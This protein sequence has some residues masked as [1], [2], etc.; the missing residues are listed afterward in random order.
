[1]MWTVWCSW[2]CILSLL[3]MFRTKQEREKMKQK[4]VKNLVLVLCRSAAGGQNCCVSMLHWCAC[5][6][7][8]ISSQP[9]PSTS[10]FMRSPG[11]WSDVWVMAEHLNA[12]LTSHYSSSVCPRTRMQMQPTRNPTRAASCEGDVGYCLCYLLLCFSYRTV[13]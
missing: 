2:P 9:S 12:L 6:E 3:V 5:P 1:M 11:P 13:H 10:S 8:C 4:D 7:G